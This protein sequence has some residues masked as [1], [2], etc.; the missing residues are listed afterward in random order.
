MAALL[1]GA[2][3]KFLVK[4]LRRRLSH[5]RSPDELDVINIGKSPY[6]YVW[7]G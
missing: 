1:D 2:N 6:F 3:D 4:L 5:G 7:T